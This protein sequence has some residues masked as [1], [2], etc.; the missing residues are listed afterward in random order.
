MIGI[1]GDILMAAESSMVAPLPS[2]K[3]I[4]RYLSVLVLV[5]LAIYF[6]LPRIAAVEY[7]LRAVSKFGVSF[8]ALSLAAQLLR[9]L[10]SGYMLRAAVDLPENRVSIIE[11]TLLT[12]GANTVGT[13]GGGVVGTAGMTYF[14]LR[15]RG[16]NPAAA[17]LG[18]WL[19][20]VLKNALLAIISTG[21]VLVMIHHKKTSHVLGPEFL[22][23][24]LILVGGTAALLWCWAHRRRL[25][26]I[27]VAVAGIF[28]KLRHK[29]FDRARM[30]AAFVHLFQEWDTLLRGRWYAPSLGAILSTSFD[31]LTLAFLF[32]AVGYHIGPFV[33][34]AGYGLPQF[35]GKLTVVMGG[36]G[37]VET[38]MVGLY[39]LLDVPKPTAVVV[40][41]AYRAL[42]F[43][44]P[45]LIGL[46]LIPYLDRESRTSSGTPRTSGSGSTA[47]PP[48]SPDIS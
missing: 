18:G 22:V 9:Y 23:S 16:V 8:I 4:K 38:S 3:K 7:D 40:V 25:Q 31:I 1:S 36:V 47:K 27:A 21:G 26:S 33:L 39:R 44:L 24:I 37:V 32:R 11:G 17:S 35:L 46:A 2:R 42:S 15:Q 43:W 13:L 34:V 48:R 29:P 41:L 14:F 20:I 28:A 5:G 6:F 19:P 30:D 12:A 10:G 45:T